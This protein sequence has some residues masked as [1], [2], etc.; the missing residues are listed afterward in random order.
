MNFGDEVSWVGGH[1]SSGVDMLASVSCK[2]GV[3]T[4]SFR[5]FSWCSWVENS[6]ISHVFI[7]GDTHINAHYK[8]LIYVVLNPC[9]LTLENTQIIHNELFENN[10]VQ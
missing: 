8:T 5:M 3:G 10:C 9:I 7:V 4:K 1:P 6:I 2:D